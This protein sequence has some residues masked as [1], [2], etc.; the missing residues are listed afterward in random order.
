MADISSELTAI[1]E[2]N[3]GSDVRQAIYSGLTQINNEVTAKKPVIMIDCGTISSLPKTITNADI[4]SK[5]I[6]VNQYLS[7][8][9]A[10]AN[11]WTV[12]TFDGSLRIEGTVSTNQSTS[13]ILY[14]NEILD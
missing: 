5:M 3:Y 7:N 4:T 2:A 9:S 6:V 11:I 8:I 1:S 13:L 10:Q 12:Y 14:L